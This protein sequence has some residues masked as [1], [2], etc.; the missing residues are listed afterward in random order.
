MYPGI[1][2]VATIDLIRSER[3][4]PA[5]ASPVRALTME[6]PGMKPVA[7][8]A[9]MCWICRVGF[10]L[11]RRPLGAAMPAWQASHPSRRRDSSQQAASSGCF[12]RCSGSRLQLLV[13]SG[14]TPRSPDFR[15]LGLIDPT[16]LVGQSFAEAARY[17]FC[18]C[19]LGLVA[20]ACAEQCAG[21]RG[22]LGIG[23]NIGTGR[24]HLQS[25]GAR[26]V[27]RRLCQVSGNLLAAQFAGYEGVVNR[28]Q[29]S[30]QLVVQV[31]GGAAQ[32]DFEAGG[33]RRVRDCGRA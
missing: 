5:I 32:D 23:G 12:F 20:C 15:R 28:H 4:D 29:P 24:D 19:C 7:T 8:N 17:G 3:V 33:R 2:P 6:I 1:K 18:W 13:A 11:A 14:L 9:K 22:A 30:C 16:R 26:I 31:C 25:L 10:E 27:K 21:L